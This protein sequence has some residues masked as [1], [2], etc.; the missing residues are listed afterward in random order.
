MLLHEIGNRF[1]TVGV[2]CEILKHCQLYDAL[3]LLK[4]P[5]RSVFFV[6]ILQHHLFIMKNNLIFQAD[7]VVSYVSVILEDCVGLCMRTAYMVY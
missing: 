3:S 5:G 2:L 4:E 7:S 6:R 1:C